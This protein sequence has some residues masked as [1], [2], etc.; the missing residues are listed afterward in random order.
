MARVEAESCAV[1]AMR[2]REEM[3]RQDTHSQTRNTN[4]IR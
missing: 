3:R 4:Q 1:I 2:R